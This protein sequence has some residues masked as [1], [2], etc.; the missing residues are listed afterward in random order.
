MRRF[1]AIVIFGLLFA[2][3][4]IYSI[5]NFQGFW[6]GPRASIDFPKDGVSLD[7][8]HISVAGRAKRASKLELNG[9]PIY[10][11]EN[12]EFSED[13]ILSA[14][15]NIIELKAEDR[16]GREIRERRQVLVKMPE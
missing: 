12:G 7:N 8:S 4:I 15:L 2:S 9:R 14:G 5:F 3:F 6:Q 10:T 16:F 11:D 1:A 13:L